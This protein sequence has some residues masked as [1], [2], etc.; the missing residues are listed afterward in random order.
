MR[1]SECAE[2]IRVRQRSRFLPEGITPAERPPF[3][4]ED[5]IQVLVT[6]FMPKDLA[7]RAQKMVHAIQQVL[8]H[9]RRAF[10][11][12]DAFRQETGAL[13]YANV[14][15]AFRLSHGWDAC[16]EFATN[17]GG[18]AEAGSHLRVAQGEVYGQ[19]PV[20]KTVKVAIPLRVPVVK[21]RRHGGG[22]GGEVGSRVG[23]GGCDV[24]RG[25]GAGGIRQQR[26]ANRHCERC[27]ADPSHRWSDCR[28]RNFQLAPTVP[29]AR[30]ANVNA[31]ATANSGNA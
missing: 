9:E 22:G 12:R 31:V 30:R 14:L 2:Y 25:G 29:G 7:A 13:A 16:E 24:D 3:V 27:D 20:L 10:G 23:V 6:A 15:R 26:L 18:T 28:Y 21:T 4:I 11:R 5:F 8:D 17:V 19:Q 1:Q